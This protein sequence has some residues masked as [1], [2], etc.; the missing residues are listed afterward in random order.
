MTLCAPRHGPN[1]QPYFGVSPENILVLTVA[2]DH[3]VVCPHCS[4]LH[5]RL[6]AG[7]ATP[8]ALRKIADG[9]LAAADALERER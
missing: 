5:V 8:A 7:E 1:E 2:P 3:V 9:F 6:L 4:D